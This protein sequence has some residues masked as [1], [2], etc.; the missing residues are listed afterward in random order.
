MLAPIA[1]TDGGYRSFSGRDLAQMRVARLA[2][3]GPYVVPKTLAAQ[4]AR[5]AALDDLEAALGFARRFQALVAAEETRARRAAEALDHWASAPASGLAEPGVVI[6]VAAE[7]VGA[8][9]AALRDWERNGLIAVRRDP[10]NGYRRYTNADIDRL[11]VIRTLLRARYSAMSVLRMMT[12]LDRGG[13]EL[14]SRVIRC[15]ARGRDR[16][17]GDRPVAQCAPGGRRAGRASVAR[18]QGVDDQPI[19]AR[20]G[21][22]PAFERRCIPA[23]CVAPRSHIADMLVRRALPAGRLAALG[24]TPGSTTGCLQQPST[25]PP[26]STLGGK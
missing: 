10:A 16:L 23:G 8:S 18:D 21:T 24:A 19:A 22:P 9:T 11:R 14:P 25:G 7:H 4:A 13:R 5:H 2:V 6:S 12:H 20:G 17:L 26:T 3:G 15:A 1:R